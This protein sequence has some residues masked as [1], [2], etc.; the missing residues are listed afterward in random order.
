[1]SG[2]YK[3]D[4]TQNYGISLL[5]FNKQEQIQEVLTFM[6]PFPAQQREMLRGEE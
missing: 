5:V 1:V 6:A 3:G 2:E 4:Y